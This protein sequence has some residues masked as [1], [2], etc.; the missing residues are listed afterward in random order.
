MTQTP[1]PADSGDLFEIDESAVEPE[2]TTNLVDEYD[3]V[4]L[5]ENQSTEANP[6]LYP[7]DEGGS[8]D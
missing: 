5:D 2:K 6:G 8:G 3:D 7:D 4:E 1:E